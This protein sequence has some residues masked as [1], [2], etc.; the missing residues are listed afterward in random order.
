MI[1]KQKASLKFRFEFQFMT[2]YNSV[3]ISVWGKDASGRLNL[4]HRILPS[5][6]NAIPL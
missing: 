2:V 4:K 1:L 6:L 3:Q 5:E